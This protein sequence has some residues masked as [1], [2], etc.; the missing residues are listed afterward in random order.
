VAALLNALDVADKR[1][2]RR[3]EI[4]RGSR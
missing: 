3:I 2:R 1:A 4:E